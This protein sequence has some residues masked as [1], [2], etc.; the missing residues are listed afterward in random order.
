VISPFEWWLLIVGL[1]AGAGLGWLV[2]ADLRRRED[3]LDDRER[4][5]EAAW[6]A[7]TLEAQGQGL[8][9]DAVEEVLALH[10]WYLREPPHVEA[11]DDPGTDGGSGLVYQETDIPASE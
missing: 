8:P 3:D 4:A 5:D 7:A 6:I 11:T 2:L 10:R 1:A 9:T